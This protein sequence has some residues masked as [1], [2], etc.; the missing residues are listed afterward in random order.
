MG[1]KKGILLMLVCTAFTAFGQLFLKKGADHMFPLFSNFELFFG[2][3]LYG[4]G[5]LIMIYALKFGELSILYPVVSLTFIWVTVLSI[6]FL[7]ESIA[8]TQYLGIGTILAGVI[9]L[10]SGGKR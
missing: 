1:L 6:T 4:V 3:F 9:M 10:S 7:G 8:T 5:A 2:L